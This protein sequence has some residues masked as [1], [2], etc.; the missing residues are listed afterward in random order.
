MPNQVCNKPI[1]PSFDLFFPYPI[2]NLDCRREPAGEQRW[3]LGWGAGYPKHLRHVLDQRLHWQRRIGGLPFWSRGREK[4][5]L[6]K[7]ASNNYYLLFILSSCGLLYFNNKARKLVNNYVKP[8]FTHTGLW[9][10]VRLRRPPVSLLGRVRHL[11]AS[12]ARAWGTV[13]VIFR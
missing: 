5:G 10:G 1:L 12:R 6:I 9:S 8:F 11:P 2:F 13:P 3:Y 4:H 7:I